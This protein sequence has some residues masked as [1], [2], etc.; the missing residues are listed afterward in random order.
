MSAR[1]HLA[2][3]G[4]DDG[5]DIQHD[6]LLQVLAHADGLEALLPVLVAVYV[7]GA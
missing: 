7:H 5:L 3:R 6:V 4:V 1:L 2:P